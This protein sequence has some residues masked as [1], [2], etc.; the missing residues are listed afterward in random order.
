MSPVRRLPKTVNRMPHR[1]T[2]ENRLLRWATLLLL[3]AVVLLPT[4][5]FLAYTGDLASMGILGTLLALSG[6]CAMVLVLRSESL[7]R[8]RQQRHTPPPAPPAVPHCAHCGRTTDG[9]GG[10]TVWARAQGAR[11]CHPD[12]KNRPD[13]FHLVTLYGHQ[14]YDCP[15][16]TPALTREES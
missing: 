12:E 13:C 2:T 1:Y 11:L 6:I 8:K 16:C 4:C 7:R 9:R 5:V 15:D 14:L 10:N 3:P